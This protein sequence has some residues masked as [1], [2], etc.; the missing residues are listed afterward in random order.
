MLNL[1]PNVIKISS[2]TFSNT[3]KLG[4]FN[5]GMDPSGTYGDTRNSGFWNGISPPR[6]GY[7]VYTS[8]IGRKDEPSITCHDDRSLTDWVNSAYQQ[9][10]NRVDDAIQ[11]LNIQSGDSICVNYDYPYFP[12]NGLVLN[13]DLW[14]TPSYP[15]KGSNIY[16]TS[17]ILSTGSSGSGGVTAS[18]PNSSTYSDNAIYLVGDQTILIPRRESVTS[19][20]NNSNWTFVFSFSISSSSVGLFSLSTPSTA[21]FSL[22][23]S[24]DNLYISSDSRDV[25]LTRLS[26]NT[27]YL[28]AMKRDLS[29]DTKVYISIDGVDVASINTDISNF[30]NLVFGYATD[31]KRAAYASDCTIYSIKKYNVALSQVDIYGIIG[32]ITGIYEPGAFFVGYDHVGSTSNVYLFQSGTAFKFTP[33]RSGTIESGNVYLVDNDYPGVPGVNKVSMAIYS[34]TGGVPKDVLAYSS[35]Q[36]SPTGTPDWVNFPSFTTE[37]LIDGSLVVTAGVPIW[38][39]VW[40]NAPGIIRAYSDIGSTGQSS[41][42]NSDE[43]YPNWNVWDSVALR[44]EKISVYLTV[45]P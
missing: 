45:T 44:D 1:V 31:S 11:Y 28:I 40:T 2:A 6:D 17:N 12:T 42:N 20:P 5:I 15:K 14:F 30:D 16:D 32:S 37:G 36:E 21:G 34:N 9:T 19:F 27:R 29:V 35:T 18:I 3:I 24:G 43:T 8:V 26:I 23:V 13:Y 33:S 10:F 39:A 41:E 38:I 7:T 22:F 4:R 25:L